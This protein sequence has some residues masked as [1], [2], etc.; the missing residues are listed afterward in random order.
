MSRE[1]GGDGM[2]LCSSSRRERL[3]IRPSPSPSGAAARREAEP[4]REIAT[5][6]GAVPGLSI[7]ASCASSCAAERCT[8]RW[9]CVAPPQ[10]ALRTRRALRGR[11]RGRER[12]GGR[13]KERERRRAAAP[14]ARLEARRIGAHLAHPNGER[15][16]ELHLDSAPSQPAVV[17]RERRQALLHELARPAL[18]LLK[19]G[20]VLLTRPH[21]RLDERLAR[22]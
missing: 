4:Q 21:R 1:K 8:R 11:A 6:D 16:V 18:A 5:L 3:R 15:L 2:G 10:R 20:L 9:W 7:S 13:E 14:R 19:G 22:R 17:L 12:E